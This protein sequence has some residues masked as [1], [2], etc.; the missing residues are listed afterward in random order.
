M[1][2][3]VTPVLLYYFATILLVKLSE[4]PLDKPIS[5]IRV[6]ISTR[7]FLKRASFLDNITI[8]FSETAKE[9]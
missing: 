8:V 3:Y 6:V 9:P 4:K 5:K 1:Y 2:Q 7:S